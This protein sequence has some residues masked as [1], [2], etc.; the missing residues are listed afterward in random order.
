MCDSHVKML[1]A[2]LDPATLA[3]LCENELTQVYYRISTT[4]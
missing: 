4:L 1:L 3:C 2:G